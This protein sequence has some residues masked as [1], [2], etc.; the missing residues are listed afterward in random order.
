MNITP[1]MLGE[2]EAAYAEADAARAVI[3]GPTL[4][5]AEHQAACDR[6]AHA[7]HTLSRVLHRYGRSLARLYALARAEISAHRT[8]LDV[9]DYW[10]D[11][12]RNIHAT[13]KD[14]QRA[15]AVMFLTRDAYYKAR[16]A[17]DA[18]EKEGTT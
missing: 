16:A 14:Y 4:P 10:I 5:D 2:I 13:E 11:L 12:Q 18:A 1:E 8:I 6:I 3:R 15:G 17:L 7:E 9:R